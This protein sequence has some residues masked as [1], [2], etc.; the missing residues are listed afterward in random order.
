MPAAS[1]AFCEPVTVASLLEI[2]QILLTLVVAVE[3]ALESSK[4]SSFPVALGVGKDSTCQSNCTL[5]TLFLPMALITGVAV[6]EM[7]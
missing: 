2:I 5:L 7:L 3:A 6:G 4:P 1:E